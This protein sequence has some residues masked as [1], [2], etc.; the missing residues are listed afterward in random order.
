MMNLNESVKIS[1]LMTIFEEPIEW[2]KLSI[3]SL[4]EDL[5]LGDEVIVI[6]DNPMYSFIN[7]LEYIVSKDE[8]FSV[9]INEKNIGLSKS[10][11]RAFQVAKGLFIA[12]MDADDVVIKG[13]FSKSLSYL[14]KNSLDFV[15]TGIIEIDKNGEPINQISSNF[16][17]VGNNNLIKSLKYQNMLWH[18][19][20]LIRREV[21]EKNDGY[22]D[23]FGAEDYDFIVRALLS[24]FSIGVLQKPLLY[25]RISSKAI[26]GKYAYVQFLNAE[27]IRKQL[28]TQKL[29][30]A[31][32]FYYKTYDLGR[33]QYDIAKD[34]F[35]IGSRIMKIA[36]LL[37]S[38]FFYGGRKFIR[39]IYLNKRAWSIGKKE[40]KS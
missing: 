39:N 40:L 3:E 27:L 30:P 15:S 36:Y 24:G 21:F 4:A 33:L 31:E 16:S 28:S 38:V 9:Y 13:R 37:R 23:I 34:R 12:R 17:Y 8:R 26:S 11:N 35:E 14:Q 2:V 7:Q 19:T 10:L 29:I 22:R 25:K 5:D 6:V 18:P 20:W 32:D 1:V